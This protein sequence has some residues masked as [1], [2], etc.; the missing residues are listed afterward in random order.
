MPNTPIAIAQGISLIYKNENCSKAN[1]R[2]I[3]TWFEYCGDVIETKTE[4]EFDELM[5]FS[6]SGPGYLFYIADA[7][8]QKLVSMG[9]DINTARKLINKLFVGSS[10]L[11]GQSEESLNTLCKNVTSKGGVTQAAL[12]HL[13]SN[14]LHKLISDSISAANERSKQLT[15]I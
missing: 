4:K 8:F 15:R 14:Y 11:M 5:L 9:H 13:E 3:K 10:L 12:E 6:G 1:S 2:M 7:Y